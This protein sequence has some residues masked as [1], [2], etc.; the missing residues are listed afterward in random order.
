MARPARFTA[1]LVVA[2]IALLVVAGD[3]ALALRE[4]HQRQDDAAAAVAAARAEVTGLIGISDATSEEDLREL[5]DGATAEFR[6]ELSSQ[7]ARLRA[8]LSAGDVRAEGRVVSA[9]VSRM[10]GRTATVVVAATG[11][12]RNRQTTKA[13]PRSYRLSVEVERTG[14]RWLVAGLEFVA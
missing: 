13:E 2:I 9:G 14:G 11:T 1:V 10:S 5:L 4:Q 7:A 12:V 8:A 3:R 6:K